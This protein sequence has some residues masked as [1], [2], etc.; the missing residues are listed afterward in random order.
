MKLKLETISRTSRMD[1]LVKASTLY[2]AAKFPDRR[3]K[4]RETKKAEILT[5]W[6]NERKGFKIGNI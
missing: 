5:A 4:V 3:P 1:K 2:A 6:E